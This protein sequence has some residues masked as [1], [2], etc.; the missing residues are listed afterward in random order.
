MSDQAFERVGAIAAAIVA[1][2]SL[3]YTVAYL[4]VTPSAQ[5]GSDVGAFAR[6]YL[7]HPAGLRIA[8]TCLLVSGIASGLAV[9]SLT[10]RL[11]HAP[12]TARTWVATAG[13]IAGLATSAHGL[14]DLVGVDKLAHRY[15]TG[16]A[17]T[18]AAVSLEH[19]LP[20]AV[21]PR[22]LAT[23]G[24]AGAVAL[25][26]GLMLRA[27]RPR[28]GLLGVVLGIDLLA[29][30]VATAVGIQPLVLVTGGLAA[31]VL[32]PIWWGG[33]ARLLWRSGA[34]TMIGEVRRPAAGRA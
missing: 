26:L 14:A 24:V 21:D 29:L 7:A 27:T 3:L 15:A 10:G 33:I 13:I 12:A 9:V 18:R 22:G 4:G 28:L 11:A 8:S 32:G 31:V 2:L 23:F 16:G 19:A 20:S 17:G 30:F 5:R 1:A 6:S 34:T 25:I